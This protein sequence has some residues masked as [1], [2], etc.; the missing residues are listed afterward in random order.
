MI[1]EHG[2]EQVR[3]TLAG[4]GEVSSSSA[5]RWDMPS[6]DLNGWGAWLYPNLLKLVLGFP[7]SLGGQMWLAFGRWEP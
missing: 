3:P 7:L 4:G 5:G 6:K 1:Y 2:S